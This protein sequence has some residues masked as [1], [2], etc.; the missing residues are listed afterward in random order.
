MSQEKTQAELLKEELFFEKK[1]FS[2]QMSEEELAKADAFCEGYKDFL[3]KG[4]TERECVNYMVE[5]AEAKGFVAFDNKKTYKAG[6]KVYLNNRGK[7]IILAVMGT[8]GVSEGAKIVAAHI[9]SPRLD[10]KPTPLYEADELA[11]FK[12]H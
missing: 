11:Y 10:L 9:D 1:H 4:K 2:N 5:A 6:D 3:E 7:S 12:T 8:K